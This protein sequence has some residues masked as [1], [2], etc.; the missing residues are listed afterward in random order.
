[1]KSCFQSPYTHHDAHEQMR[2]IENIII[3][4]L[5]HLFF[6]IES[7]LFTII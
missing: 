7:N 5:I 1:M 2:S 4:T 6:Q 3:D